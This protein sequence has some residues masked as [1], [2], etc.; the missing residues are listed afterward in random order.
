MATTT[1]NFGWPVPTSSDLV[2]NGATAIEGL[3]DAIDASLLDLKGGTSG[4]VLAKASGTDMDFSWVTDATGIPATIFDAKGDIIA[5]TAADTAGRL[6]VGT[7][8]QTLVADSTASTGLKWATPSGATASWSQIGSA[9]TTS[10]TTVTVS[11]LS[12]Y[13]QIFASFEAISSS[14]T[15]IHNY[16]FRLNTDSG[17]NYNFSSYGIRNANQ[18]A[19]SYTAADTSFYVARFA[20]GVSK[21]AGGFYIN[22]ANGTSKKYVQGFSA[23]DTDSTTYDITSANLYGTYDGTSVISS[24]SIL[25]SATAFD[26]GT[27]RV[28]GSVA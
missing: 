27:L 15:A 4:Q 12:G 16:T 13:N 1:P 21:L 9:A 26:S 17:A 14:G 11:G 23:I 6:A 10:G 3:G 5:A 22:G 25:T 8:G 24:V 28:F 20:T 2:K 7:N 19:G 18:V